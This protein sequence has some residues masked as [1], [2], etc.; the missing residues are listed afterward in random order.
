MGTAGM[1][2]GPRDFVYHDMSSVGYLLYKEMLIPRRD[3]MLSVHQ[4]MKAGT[5]ECWGRSVTVYVRKRGSKPLCA[6]QTAIIISHHIKWGEQIYLSSILIVNWR[7]VCC[8]NSTYTSHNDHFTL[9]N[10]S[11]LWRLA[12]KLPWNS[13]QNDGCT[14]SIVIFSRIFEQIKMAL[15]GPGGGRRF[16]KKTCSHDTVP[17]NI[18]AMVL[19][20]I[21]IPSE[22][23]FYHIL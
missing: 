23:L 10:T 4:L 13:K 6:Q 17:L 15:R 16:M 20:S 19:R 14:F 8:K 7:A 12:I 3:K 22:R 5:G 2:R 18:A 11:L 9:R 1:I 21:D